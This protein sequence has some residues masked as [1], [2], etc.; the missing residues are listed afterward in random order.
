MIESQPQPHHHHQSHHQYNIINSPLQWTTRQS[1][2][3]TTAA[4]PTPQCSKPPNTRPPAP[5]V[6][7]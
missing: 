5:V 3:A 6:L 1:F 2:D 4:P 7:R